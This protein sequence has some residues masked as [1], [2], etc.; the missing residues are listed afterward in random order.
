MELL[1]PAG[2]LEKLA[3]AYRYGADAAY[4]GVHG[5]SL[6]AWADTLSGDPGGSSSAGEGPLDGADLATELRRIKPPGKRL[7][8]ALNLFAHDEDLRRLPATLAGL[9]GLPIDAVIIADLGLIDTV[10]RELPDVE[11]H[12]STQANCTNAAAARLYHRL[13]FSR[14]IPSRELSLPEIRT[15]KEAVP[16]LGVE[17]FVHGAMCMAYSGRC[18]LSDFM[19][20]RSAN[21]GDC[22][23]SC[24]WNYRVERYHLEEEKRPGE[25]LTAE[26]DGRFTAILSSRDLNLFD[27]LAEITAAGVDAIKIEGR[28]KSSLYVATVTRAYRA[29][30][31]GTADRDAHR[32]ALDTVSHREYTTGFLVDDGTVSTPAAR[33]AAGTYRMMGILEEPSGSPTSTPN[34]EPAAPGRAADP[35]PASI[36][37]DA[38]HV[39]VKN[40]IRRGVT[41][42][43]LPTDPAAPPAIPDPEFELYDPAG[44]PTDQITNAGHG[45][46][47]PSPS[48]TTHLR[49]GTVIRA[50]AIGQ[51]PQAGETFGPRIRR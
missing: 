3:T 39:L 9:R 37:H 13:G 36:P 45:Y 17:V 47:R 25:Y 14:I 29:A 35:P 38:W 31:D 11:L 40:T 6:R 21:R 49:P 12:L 50:R 48:A 33:P 46:L 4:I 15:I 7:Y 5:F 16:E 19:A 26:T 18:F 24:R 10:R 22:A 28:M 43:Y 1:A 42:E 20:D 41:L 34:T 8:A 2:N 44:N 30:L 32:L 27:Y 23:Q 51:T